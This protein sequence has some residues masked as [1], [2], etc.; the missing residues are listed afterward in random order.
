MHPDS[1]SETE[2]EYGPG[3]VDAHLHQSSVDGQRAEQQSHADQHEGGASRD[4]LAQNLTQG[5]PCHTTEPQSP[6]HVELRLVSSESIT[7]LS[8]AAP[9]DALGCKGDW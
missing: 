4:P 3:E 8:S 5:Q 7:L 9:V 1:N 6:Q 2:E